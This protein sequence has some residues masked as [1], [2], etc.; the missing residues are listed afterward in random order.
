[1]Q[2]AKMGVVTG[3]NLAELCRCAPHVCRRAYKLATEVNAT[4]G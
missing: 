2:A 3:S 1:M 4:K